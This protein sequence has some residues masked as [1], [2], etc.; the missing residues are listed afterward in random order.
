LGANEE[1]DVHVVLESDRWDNKEEGEMSMS[2]EIASSDNAGWTK[3][4]TYTLHITDD[5]F[6]DKSSYSPYDEKRERLR[7]MDA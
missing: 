1:K 6:G 2:L 5:M 4:A 7:K 3:H